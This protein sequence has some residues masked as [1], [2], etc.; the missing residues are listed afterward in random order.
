MQYIPINLINPFS[1][2]GSPKDIA[3]LSAKFQCIADKENVY[4]AVK[5][6][7]D[8][9]IFGEAEIGAPFWDDCVEILFYGYEKS[10]IPLKIWISAG[11]YGE[12]K[13]EG[14]DQKSLMSYPFLLQNMGVIA[15]IK[16]MENGYNIE[17]SIPKNILPMLNNIYKLNIL[18][19]DDDFGKTDYVIEWKRL[20]KNE[21]GI[22][23]TNK[24]IPQISNQ[25]YFDYKI[26]ISNNE[27]KVDIDS[28]IQIAL[29]FNKSGLYKKSNEIL[30]QLIVNACD[31]KH[32]GIIKSLII[33]NYY[34]LEQYKA[35]K[36]ISIQMLNDNAEFTNDAKSILK[37]IELKEYD[38]KE[39]AFPVDLLNKYNRVLYMELYWGNKN[40][41]I[42]FV[43]NV[44]S[45]IHG[46]VPSFDIDKNGNA[47]FLDAGNKCV[48]IFKNNGKLT[49]MFPVTA[50]Y[51]NTMNIYVD[52][53]N[54]IW[55]H[56][57]Y[58]KV[59][60]NYDNDGKLNKSI[61]YDN[62]M[63]ATFEIRNGLI[64]GFNSE[65]KILNKLN[66]KGVFDEE[67][68]SAKVEKRDEYL[69]TSYNSGKYS[70]KIYLFNE[71]EYDIK[72][73]LVP[74]SFTIRE[75]LIMRNITINNINPNY[76]LVFKGED[77]HGNYYFLAHTYVG[78]LKQH[79]IKVDSNDKISGIIEN[80][81]LT[82]EYVIKK[83]IV[84]DENGNVYI[85]KCYD[86]R[87]CVE[88]YIVK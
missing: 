16:K 63:S 76:K 70:K 34:C 38:N 23:K 79:I 77:K 60:R 15:N 52:E 62:L 78:K 86:D 4:V 61:M 37:T 68:Y 53:M 5:V 84:I 31:L 65:V 9:V 71:N 51:Y 47:Y 80:L 55:V 3:N 25:S 10:N 13:L 59:I 17:A 1:N 85:L 12:I 40:E 88:K 39:D 21:Y 26:N 24:I 18:V 73:G 8:K 22:I 2:L 29:A 7:D 42:G 64:Y 83:P 14:R 69:P 74:I 87:I 57:P 67:V 11:K 81:D 44:Y 36:D 28:K 27:E 45:S 33:N 41:Q 48:K 43:S 19:Y 35:A 72:N 50:K 56:E 46:G 30:L 66:Y 58:N 20:Q 49:K 54:N 6:T 75:N 82:K 32:I